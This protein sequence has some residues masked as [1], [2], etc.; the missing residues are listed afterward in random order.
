MSSSRSSYLCALRSVTTLYELEERQT[1]IGRDPNNDLVLDG[2]KGVSR[3]HARLDCTNFNAPSSSS[4]GRNSAAQQS[5]RLSFELVDLNSANGT[6]VN[7]ERLYPREPRVLR[8]GDLLFFSAYSKNG[9][10]FE[11][12]GGPDLGNLDANVNTA[13]ARERMIGSGAATPGAAE[14]A[15]SRSQSRSGSRTPIHYPAGAGGG[16]DTPTRWSERGRSPLPGGVDPAFAYPTRSGSIKCRPL[17]EVLPSKQGDETDS[18][19]RKRFR[20]LNE[21][22]I[23]RESIDASW[24]EDEAGRVSPPNAS[25]KLRHSRIGMN[26][27]L[28]SQLQNLEDR[29]DQLHQLELDKKKQDRIQREKASESVWKSLPLSVASIKQACEILQ[30]LLKLKTEDVEVGVDGHLGDKSPRI[31]EDVVMAVRNGGDGTAN[32]KTASEEEMQPQR[33]LKLATVLEELVD[34]HVN[35]D[36]GALVGKKGKKGKAK[37]LKNVRAKAV[38]RMKTRP[39]ERGGGFLTGVNGNYSDG[40]GGRKPSRFE[41]AGAIQQLYRGGQ[42]ISDRPLTREE[43]EFLQFTIANQEQELAELRNQLGDY[44]KYLP[45][46]FASDVDPSSLAQWRDRLALRPRL[47]VEE[48][49]QFMA[50]IL[51][52]ERVIQEYGKRR[53]TCARRWANLQERVGALRE[54]AAY[55]EE[56][57]W[58]MPAAQPPE[59]AAAVELLA[60]FDKLER[61]TQAGLMRRFD[62]EQATDQLHDELAGH[63]SRREMLGAVADNDLLVEADVNVTGATA[64]ADHKQT[65]RFKKGQSAR[66]MFS[67][68]ATVERV[69]NLEKLCEQLEWE[70][71]RQQRPGVHTLVV[72]CS[73]ADI[74]GENAATGGAWLAFDADQANIKGRITPGANAT[75]GSNGEVENLSNLRELLEEVLAQ[76]AE[77]GAEI[78]RRA[79]NENP[80]RGVT[81]HARWNGLEQPASDRSQQVMNAAREARPAAEPPAGTETTSNRPDGGP[82]RFDP[83]SGVWLEHRVTTSQAR[84]MSAAE[85]Y[86]SLSNPRY[87]FPKDTSAALERG[88]SYPNAAGLLQRQNSRDGFDYGIHGGERETDAAT[89]GGGTST[90]HRGRSPPRAEDVPEP[91]LTELERGFRED[92]RP[93]DPAAHWDKMAKQKERLERQLPVAIDVSE[94]FLKQSGVADAAADEEIARAEDEGAMRKDEYIRDE[95]AQFSS[96]VGIV[97]DR[98]VIG[99]F[100]G[101]GAA[102]RR[103]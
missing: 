51:D 13:P 78:L 7:G 85:R 15:G 95:G 99:S 68:M 91:P 25:D 84:S 21:R 10:R 33:L 39:G 38:G 12:F 37:G 1:T 59:N 6:F 30:G 28:K 31:A 42:G 61:E 24:N 46:S 62:M 96:E 60:S 54:Q 74:A 58:K 55:Y 73:V 57:V 3:F 98:I 23:R 11:V 87:G 27:E 103:L 19:S 4:A 43:R 52:A 35:G 2:S 102:G 81:L 71:L 65:G 45:D 66:K 53:E 77:E 86:R 40:G 90:H 67:R 5:H 26:P 97:S 92:W 100:G 41:D 47:T 32:E 49:A 44:L 72:R 22:E 29:L 16:A 101:G 9:M 36:A 50:K 18:P 69:L 76:N 80:H 70:M 48:S 63:L 20:E 94:K 14:A 8:H 75:S 88:A 89:A 79:E 64:G 83:D 93:A 34:F 17:Q 82:L 56:Q